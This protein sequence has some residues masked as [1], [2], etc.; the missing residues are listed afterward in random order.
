[1][2]LGPGQAL[3]R[4]CSSFRAFGPPPDRL[5]V[6][7][8]GGR[9]ILALYAEKGRVLI[10]KLAS[11]KKERGYQFSTIEEFELWCD[12]VEPLL[13]VSDKHEREFVQAKNR[14]ISCYRIDS[15]R[16][17]FSNMDEAIGVLNRAITFLE[18]K[19]TAD[20][21]TSTELAYPQKVTIPWLI[22][23]VEVKHWVALAGLAVAIFF[24]GVNLG[25]SEFY[26]SYFQSESSEESSR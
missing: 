26:Q 18:S 1:M 12:E 11:L 22:R 13:S 6:A 10:E 7:L 14:A 9:L 23:H 25:S 5:S 21:G 8:Q 3:T 24:A 2:L 15:Y 19:P 16:D 20:A 17:Y 4:Y